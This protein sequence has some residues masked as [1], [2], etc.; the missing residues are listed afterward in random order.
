[1]KYGINTIDDFE[2]KGKTILCRIDV[3]QPVNKETGELKDLTRIIGC[4]PT[5]RELT[6]K[7]AK[8]VLMSHQGGDLE[9]NN[10]YATKAHL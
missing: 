3:N 4:V 5:L 1:M 10:Y 6:D 8:L 9:Y 7:G 2:I